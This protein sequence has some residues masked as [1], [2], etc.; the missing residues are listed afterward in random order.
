MLLSSLMLL[1]F[2]FTKTKNIRAGLKYLI[3]MHI[4]V[5]F[6]TIGFIWIHLE[7]GSFNLSAL[8]NVSSQNHSLWI[9]VLF[10][11]GFAIK[12]GFL[13]FHTWLPD[14][15]STA[16][17]HISGV[18]SGVIVKL[19]IFG[20]LRI[21]SSLHSNLFLIGEIILS[22]SVLSALYGIINAAV[23]YD[24]NRSLAYCTME[25]IGIIGMGIGL[26]VMG[27]GI[28]Q[29]LLILLGFSGA[30]LHVLNHSLFKSLLFFGTGSIFQ[31]TGTRNIEKLGGLIKT[32]P[33]TALFFLIGA[34]AIGG[35]PPFN[36]F[37]SEFLIYTGL[38]KG[39][40]AI[41][42]ISNVILLVLSIVGLVMVGG[43]SI[44]TFTRLF[45]VIFLGK[46]RSVLKN[47]AVE[48]TFIMHL[49]QYL[50]VVAILSIAIFPQF[51][52]AKSA[53]IISST[54]NSGIPIDVTQLA[55][56]YTTLSNVGVVSFYFILLL[57]G[58]FAFRT[59]MVKKRTQTHNDTWGCAYGTPI[60]KA[61]Y[62]GRS[63]ARNF[64]NLFSSILITKKS[65]VEITKGKLYPG[66]HKFSSYYFDFFELYLVNP[67]VK[68][69]S[70][71]VN[72]FQFIQNGRIQSYLIYSLIFILIVFIGTALGL[73]T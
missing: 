41:K 16:P 29:P 73:I 55:A 45:G 57:I 22:I 6:L 72:Y 1:I 30:L 31:Q 61:Q 15:D 9:V 38:F 8:A 2:D 63:Y 18:M 47:D 59:L 53:Y 5:V 28:N 40:Y 68:Q 7:T 71:F 24:F 13:P 26:G 44:I 66:Y 52:L 58:V 51:Y 27:L 11:V 49:P 14:A 62:S 54:F 19:G 69:I 33:K 34:L 20:I 43:I 25:N 67:V 4:S 56:T 3:H 17:S 42:G 32:M 35:L 37:V 70:V 12:A 23:K 10:A 60:L 65:F 39:L 48:T 21:I 46:P 64:S 50:I 36:G